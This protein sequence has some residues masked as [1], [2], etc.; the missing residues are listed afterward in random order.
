[1]FVCSLVARIS[2]TR[3]SSQNLTGKTWLPA[4]SFGRFW[5]SYQRRLN[6]SAYSSLQ[7]AARRLF[8]QTHRSEIAS[9]RTQ[10]SCLAVLGPT[11]L[12]HIEPGSDNQSSFK[13]LGKSAWQIRSS[14]SRGSATFDRWV[15]IPTAQ[16]EKCLVF[17]LSKRR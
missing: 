1:M 11:I 17:S 16:S 7:L 9:K 4:N 15:A 12:C 2:Y 3:V 10:R 5:A 6:S 14:S 13:E 8:V